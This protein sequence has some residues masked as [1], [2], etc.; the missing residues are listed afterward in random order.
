[1]FTGVY[2]L[3]RRAMKRLLHELFGISI[4]LG[5]LSRIE[6][7]ASAVRNPD[8][9]GQS[10]RSDLGSRSGDTWAPIPAHLAIW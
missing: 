9:L 7:R 10:F 1:M 6:A 2:H 3:S 4:S 5:A 8:E